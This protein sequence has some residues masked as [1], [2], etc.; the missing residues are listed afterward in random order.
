MSRRK[1]DNG[2]W[3]FKCTIRIQGENSI[4]EDYDYDEDV[5]VPL[6]GVT[7][8]SDAEKQAGSI[9]KTLKKADNE[10]INKRFFLDIQ[11]DDEISIN[12]SK[13]FFEKKL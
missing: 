11:D 1:K 8:Q 10:Y 7:N 6:D 12:R 3:F 13:L 2:G 5:Q 4:Q 9:L